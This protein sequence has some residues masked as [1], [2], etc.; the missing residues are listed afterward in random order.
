MSCRTPMMMFARASDLPPSVG[1]RTA[2]A[3]YHRPYWPEAAVRFDGEMPSTFTS[4]R[5]GKVVVL[6]LSIEAYVTEPGVVLAAVSTLPV[7]K[8]S[9]VGLTSLIGVEPDWHPSPV[10]NM[11]TLARLP[12]PCSRFTIV[13][14]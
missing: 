12:E 10:K 11:S 7:E 14:A 6:K 2:V 9:D 5:F 4:T 13:I 1:L 3:S 8:K